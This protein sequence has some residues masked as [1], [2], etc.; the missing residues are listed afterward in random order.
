[1]NHIFLDNEAECRKGKY[2]Q[3]PADDPAKFDFAYANPYVEFTYFWH[4]GISVNGVPVINGCGAVFLKEFTATGFSK[5]YFDARPLKVWWCSWKKLALPETPDEDN[6]DAPDNE[7][8]LN[9]HDGSEAEPS[10]LLWPSHG[11]WVLT[12][13]TC[14]EELPK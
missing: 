4:K 6:K 10:N 13:A 14:E 11:T 8:G 12:R 1:M 2:K 5:F 7:D 9:N 3:L